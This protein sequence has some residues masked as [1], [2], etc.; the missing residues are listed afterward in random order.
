MLPYVSIFKY[1]KYNNNNDF[2]II[3][4]IQLKCLDDYDTW[5]NVNMP[6]GTLK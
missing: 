2:E 1:L 5:P 6:H 3:W 4:D